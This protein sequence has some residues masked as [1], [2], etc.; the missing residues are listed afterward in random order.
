MKMTF[1]TPI[2]RESAIA[3]VS[4]LI[5]PELRRMGHTV[6]VIDAGQL[7]PQSVFE[8][9][10]DA[11]H[12]TDY[13]A[14]N[15]AVVTNDVSVYQIGDYY[16]F[17]A[18][19][20]DWMERDPGVVVMHDYF[21][22]GLFL[23]WCDAR[24]VNPLP[25]VEEWYGDEVAEMFRW[26]SAQHGFAEAMHEVAPMTEWIAAQALAVVTHSSWGLDR[27]ATATPG[28][29]VVAQLPYDV[30]SIVTT[31][32][33]H[34][35]EAATELGSVPA[36][37]GASINLLT[38]GH[39][40]ANRCIR[41][42]IRAIGSSPTLV[43][44]VTYQLVG[45]I[46][47]QSEVALLQLAG[48]YGVRL[49]TYGRVSAERLAGFYSHANAVV[50]LRRPCLEAASAS[51]IEAMLHGV[52]LIVLDDGWYG[53]L[54]VECVLRIPSAF[55]LD[56]LVS[57]IRSIV[58]APEASVRRAELAL[59]HAAIHLA[60]DRYAETL[61]EMAESVIRRR[62]HT[63]LV[64]SII[65]GLAEWGITDDQFDA[66]IFEPM[67]PLGVRWQPEKGSR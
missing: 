30:G 35:S 58:D 22:G 23:G 24:G 38:V 12:W 29:C 19:C 48:E 20:I 66:A 1:F 37:D 36:V 61:L 3:R 13:A 17:H 7:P 46:S 32:Q 11:S 59:Q 40:N 26:A 62:P 64:H 51:A 53:E 33:E 10:E 39:V 2:D 49:R 52:P 16:P 63:Q 47:A 60:H 44:S 41:E 55:R 45:P 9:F 54:P 42:V 15:H 14:V 57:A 28:P 50:A 5:V 56:E 6:S 4:A 31:R 18:G 25:I 27:V 43:D 8:A 67:V 34:D 21:L 65:D